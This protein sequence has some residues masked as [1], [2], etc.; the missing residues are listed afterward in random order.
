MEL[1][2]NA[3]EEVNPATWDASTRKHPGSKGA[4]ELTFTGG[5]K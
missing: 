1:I 3:R 5:Q 2:K 4:E